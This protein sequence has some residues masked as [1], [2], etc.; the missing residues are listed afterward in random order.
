[1]TVSG[2]L[3]FHQKIALP[4]AHILCI[5]V[6]Q[7]TFRERQVMNGIQD[8]GLAAAVLPEKP[9][10]L[11]VKVELSLPVIPEVLKTKVADKHDIWATSGK[12]QGIGLRLQTAGSG[13]NWY[14]RLADLK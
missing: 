9:D 7:D 12:L 1:M 13:L 4:M 3:A 5:L 11:F 14:V 8:I 10:H 2:K 6:I